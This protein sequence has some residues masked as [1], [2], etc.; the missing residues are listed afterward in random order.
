MSIISTQNQTLPSNPFSFAQNPGLLYLHD[1][2]TAAVNYLVQLIVFTLLHLM[3][4]LKAAT[5]FAT[6]SQ[7]G[8]FHLYTQRIMCK[9][10]WSFNHHDISANHVS[11]VLGLSWNCMNVSLRA[12]FHPI[13]LSK[14]WTTN[15]M[16][17]TSV[18]C[19]NK[20]L[21]DGHLT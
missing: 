19:H 21:N 5:D 18:V 9:I 7:Q 1:H 20:R 4:T 17:R 3:Y 15:R 14:L 2:P 13:F 10:F 6:D 11:N 16:N 8:H 12:L